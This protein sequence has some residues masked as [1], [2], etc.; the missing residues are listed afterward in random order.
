MRWDA[1]LDGRWGE[2][3]GQVYKSA[4]VARIVKKGLSCVARLFE[5]MP[6]DFDR[7]LKTMPLL[8]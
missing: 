5:E 2:V 3:V 1:D 6:A 4:G 7:V 8:D